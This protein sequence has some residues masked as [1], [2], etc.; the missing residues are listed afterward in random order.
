MLQVEVRVVKGVQTCCLIV[1]FYWD[2]HRHSGKGSWLCLE[3]AQAILVGIAR[4]VVLHFIEEENAV[5]ANW[6]PNVMNSFVAN[7]DTLTVHQH[8]RAMYLVWRLCCSVM[9][10][11]WQ[12]VGTH[13]SEWVCSHCTMWMGLWAWSCMH[14][15]WFKLCGA[16]VVPMYGHRCNC[17]F[18]GTATRSIQVATLNVCEALWFLGTSYLAVGWCIDCSSLQW[19]LHWGWPMQQIACASWGKGL[20]K[21]LPAVHFCDILQQLNIAAAKGQRSFKGSKKFHGN[22]RGISTLLWLS[23]SWVW[24][25]D[26]GVPHHCTTLW[27]GQ[28]RGDHLDEEDVDMYHSAEIA[29]LHS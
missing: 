1:P 2:W 5:M 12:R 18:L 26:V 16:G 23:R 17:T 28:C 15:R 8:A 13:A 19:W 20:S 3:M 7:V 21:Q 4:C 25:R 24:G 9:H 11:H 14:V 22:V 10:T 27:I 6:S 29:L